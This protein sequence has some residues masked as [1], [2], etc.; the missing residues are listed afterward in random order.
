MLLPGR[1][2]VLGLFNSLKHLIELKCLMVIEEGKHNNH[3]Q[4][5]TG[6]FRLSS[7]NFYIT[8]YAQLCNWWRSRR[9]L[10]E[11]LPKEGNC[12]DSRTI[13]GP[14]LLT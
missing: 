5:D 7:T 10:I 9:S 3:I 12:F 11:K 4:L 1:H 2:Y 6:N 13:D 14:R 8:I